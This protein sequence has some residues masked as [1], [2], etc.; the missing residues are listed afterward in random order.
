MQPIARHTLYNI[1]GQ[2]LPLAVGLVAIPIMTRSLGDTRFGLLALMWAI[3]GY[4]SLLD[5]GLGRATTKFVAE[6]LARQDARRA[7]PVAGFAAGVAAGLGFGLAAI[8]GLLLA[9]RVVTCWATWI[10]LRRA[11]PGFRWG[12]RPARELVRPLLGYGG[13]VAVTNLVSPIL[14]YLERFMLGAVAG[15]GAVAYFAAP[16]EAVSRLL[17]V[18]ASLAGVL[19]PVVS[20]PLMDDRRADAE[21]LLGRSVRSLWLL[22]GGPVIVVILLRG[23]LL[24]VWLGPVYAAR[25]ATGLSILA[26][27][28]LIIGLAHVPGIFL[29]GQGRPDLPAIFSLIE[30]PIY[31]VLAWWCVRAYGVTGAALA[32]TL[33]VTLDAVLLFAAAWKVGRFRL[34]TLLGFSIAP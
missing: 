24:A 3:I 11:L 25:G 23:P 4:F 27:G 28:M 1:L 9:L 14:T 6:A 17:L 8:V 10:A 31:V 33:R 29:Y 26:G 32:W 13:W 20:V 22:L 34:R 21:R 5:L 12:F 18:P 2:A 30:L 19:F 15:V 7:P 16:Y